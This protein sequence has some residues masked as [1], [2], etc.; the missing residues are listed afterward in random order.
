MS[1]PKSL[2]NY[3]STSLEDS[4]EPEKIWNVV[5]DIQD[6]PKTSLLSLLT[7]LLARVFIDASG[8]DNE[9]S[10]PL[11]SEKFKQS[12]DV[13]EQMQQDAMAFCDDEDNKRATETKKHLRD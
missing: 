3:P 8:E 5:H 7:A 2:T 1:N 9:T 12:K 13:V 4:W 10:E 11:C 6:S